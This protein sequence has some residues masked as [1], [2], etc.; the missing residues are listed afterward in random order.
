MSITKPVG[1]GLRAEHYA[2][3]FN[4]RPNIGWLE[5]HSE[6]YFGAGGKPLYYLE[7]I[8]RY[9]PLSFHGVG[10]SLGSTDV[11]NLLHLN[12]LKTLIDCF[13]PIMV[14]EHLCWSSINGQYLNDLLPLPYTE[15]SLNL[16]V[17]HVTQVQEYLQRPILLENISSYLQ[18]THS[19][20]PEYEFMRET[21]QRSGCGILL[22]VNNLYVN[23]KNHGWDAKHYLQR[24]P[25][26]LVKEIHLAG[27]TEN[28]FA[29]GSILI[30]SHNQPVALAVWEL[31]A[32]ALHCLGIKPTLIEWDTDMPDLAVLLSEA[33]KAGK[34]MEQMH[35]ITA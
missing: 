6:N 33:A 31:Y 24:I 16:V 28:Y 13:A 35:A 34:I 5:I 14:S 25:A 9:Y 8:S 21:A 17:K 20:I 18:F 11:I 10:L 23:S 7:Q 3:V 4:T 26:G 19:T 29:E 30:D 15:E 1:I 22:D 2:A 32:Q 27:F 12:K